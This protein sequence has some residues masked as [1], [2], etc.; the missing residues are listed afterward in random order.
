MTQRTGPTPPGVLVFGLLGVVPFW[1]LPLAWRLA[2]NGAGA[3]A[4]V[5]TAYGVLILSF[6]GGARWGGAVRAAAP[7]L[8]VVAL[9]MTPTLGG[10]AILIIT[11]GEPRLALLSVAAALMLIW[12]WDLSAKD[13]PP[14]YGRLRTVLTFGAVGGLCV[15]AMQVPR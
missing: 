4:A 5:E 1:I 12:A 7:D 14:W 10:L 3:A 15:G 13:V 2:R 11:H 9:A 8:G 6:L